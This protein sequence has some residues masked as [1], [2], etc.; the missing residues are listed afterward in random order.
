MATVVG[1]SPNG[2]EIRQRSDG[3]YEVQPPHDNWWAVGDT[4]DEA[5]RKAGWIEPE[6]IVELRE[7]LA[8]IDAAISA[9]S[10]CGI[11]SISEINESRISDA[12][13]SPWR[14]TAQGLSRCRQ[15]IEN[16]L[17]RRLSGL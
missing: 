3:K 10:E 4:V 9:F 12:L 11:A 5:M 16:L 2:R 15:E 6:D 8:S 14:E 7:Q 1:H 13:P 17:D